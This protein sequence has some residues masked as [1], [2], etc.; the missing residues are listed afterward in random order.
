MHV[1]ALALGSE[2]LPF[3]GQRI[4]RVVELK[5][6]GVGVRVKSSGFWFDHDVVARLCLLVVGC[7]EGLRNLGLR[8]RDGQRRDFQKL[9]FL[10]NCFVVRVLQVQVDLAPLNVLNLRDRVLGLVGVRSRVV[11]CILVVVFLGHWFGSG[12]TKHAIGRCG[13]TQGANKTLRFL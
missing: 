11:F 9:A 8:I 5:V 10:T 6:E 4:S 12:L 1:R 3:F 7:V 2:H 13:K